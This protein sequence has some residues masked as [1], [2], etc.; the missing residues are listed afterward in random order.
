MHKPINFSIILVCFF[1]LTNCNNFN[2]IRGNGN[3]TEQSFNVDG[4]DEV[5]VRGFYEVILEEG[6]KENV[7]I[8]CDENLFDYITVNVR[9]NT[10]IIDNEEQL[11]SQD[12]IKVYIT[13]ESLQSISCSGASKLENKGTINT[14]RL[15]VNLSGAGQLDLNVESKILDVDI[16]GAGHLMLSG[17]SDKLDLQLSGAG[18]LDAFDLKSEECDINISGVGAAEVYVTEELTA[19]LSGIGGVKYRGNP[20]HINR[21]VSGL[22]KVSK[23]ESHEDDVM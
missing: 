19:T 17:D 20:K 12:G 2:V 14:R 23:D 21:N 1:L 22:G 8:E 18:K 3:M 7:V 15:D 16:S 10:L 4:F 6:N 13:Y 11:K 5:E 9:G